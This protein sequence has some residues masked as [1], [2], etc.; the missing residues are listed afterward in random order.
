MD[1]VS[2]STDV[3]IESSSISGVIVLEEEHDGM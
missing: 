1:A 2:G 3:L